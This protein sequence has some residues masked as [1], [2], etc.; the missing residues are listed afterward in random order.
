LTTVATGPTAIAGFV[1]ALREE[2][3]SLIGRPLRYGECAAIE[4]AGL[5]Y[6]CGAGPD[7]AARAARAL[8]DRG[9]S[10]LL[11][12]GC[13]AGLAPAL[14]AGDLCLPYTILEGNGASHAVTGFWHERVRHA[15]QGHFDVHTG[16]MFS[17]RHLVADAS[18]KRALA[19]TYGAVAL[20]MES[21]AIAAAAA[22]RSVPFIALRAI[23][24]A[25]HV[26]LPR[27]VGNSLGADGAVSLYSLIGS[28]LCSPGELGALVR[29]GLG[30]RM[31]LQMLERA[32]RTLGSGFMLDMKPEPGESAR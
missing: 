22:Q 1:V 3:R 12:W 14:K 15:L 25:A 8:I 30:F 32:A 10:G 6:V 5:V 4:H 20:D 13:A 29:L 18:E 31:A 27:A 24:D 28:A 19:V 11:S 7:N 9:A 23:V 16:A 21:A 2:S 26:S 17:S